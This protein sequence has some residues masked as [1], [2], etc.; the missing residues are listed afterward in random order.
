MALDPQSEDTHVYPLDADVL[1]PS[2]PS[3]C[4]GIPGREQAFLHCGEFVI[5]REHLEVEA[6]FD[7]A[8]VT[9]HAQVGRILQIAPVGD[10]LR[11]LL[12]L[13]FLVS[14]FPIPTIRAGAAPPTEGSTLH[15][16]HTLW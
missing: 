15:T 11:I 13:L 9:V 3:F 16:Q 5:L 1:A 14:D 10:S 12:S 2:P 6:D 4:I 7:G 8:A